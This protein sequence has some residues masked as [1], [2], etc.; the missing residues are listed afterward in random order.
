MRVIGVKMLIVHDPRCV[1]YGS[2]L[3]PEQPAR[4]ARTERQL[5]QAHPDWR[6]EQPDEATVTDGVLLHAHT[7]G[8]LRSLGLGTFRGGAR[9]GVGF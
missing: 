6:W 1:E 8:H 5:R 4:V 3:R 2:Y 9:G 7:Q